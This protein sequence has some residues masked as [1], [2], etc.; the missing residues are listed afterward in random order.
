VFNLLA[1]TGLVSE[2]NFE[3]SETGIVSENILYQPHLVTHLDCSCAQA[4]QAMDNSHVAL[5]TVE[6]KA[7]QFQHYRCD[8]SIPLG[9]SVSVTSYRQPLC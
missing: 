9:I 2:A 1:I 5:V 4:L 6:L 7:E 8:R 3:C